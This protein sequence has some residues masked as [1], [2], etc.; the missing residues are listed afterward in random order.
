M[1]NSVNDKQLAMFPVV[2]IGSTVSRRAQRGV[3]SIE[4]ALIGALI[5]VVIVGTVTT[6]GLTLEDFYTLVSNEVAKVT[7]GGG[8]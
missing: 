1:G 6:L 2:T 3:T 5:A 4:Y 8:G 7:P